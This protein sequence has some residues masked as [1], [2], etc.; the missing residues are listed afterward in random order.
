VGF[1]ITGDVEMGYELLLY[2]TKVPRFSVVSMFLG[3][4]DKNGMLCVCVCVCVSVSKYGCLTCLS[5]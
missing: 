1:A 5:S 2:L 4:A 3:M